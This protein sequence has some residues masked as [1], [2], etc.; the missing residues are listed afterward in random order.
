MKKTIALLL[1]TAFLMAT[2]TACGDQ[3]D[4]SSAATAEATTG[5]STIQSSTQE[6]TTTISSDWLDTYQS[7]D[8]DKEIVLT[9]TDTGGIVDIDG[10][11]S[12]LTARAEYANEIQLVDGDG[13]VIHLTRFSDNSIDKRY[14]FAVTA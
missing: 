9:V 5:E 12:E 2:L 10:A 4:E 1:T 14:V 7:T 13:S 8:G 6:Q 3:N 11:P